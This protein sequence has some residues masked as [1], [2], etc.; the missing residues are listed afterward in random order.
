MILL[1]QA[2]VLKSLEIMGTGML[3]IFFVLGAIA[4]VIYAISAIDRKAQLKKEQQA[5]QEEQ[6]GENS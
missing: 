3:G 2:A 1:D 5:Q 6:T 4:L